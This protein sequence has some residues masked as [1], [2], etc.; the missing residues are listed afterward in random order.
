MEGGQADDPSPQL[1]DAAMTPGSQYLVTISDEAAS[2]A[3][4]RDDV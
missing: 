1:L 4:L 2:S 3:T